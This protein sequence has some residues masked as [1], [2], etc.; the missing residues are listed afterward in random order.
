MA[1][2]THV[3]I[4]CPDCRRGFH[5]PVEVEPQPGTEQRGSVLAKVK[6]AVSAFTSEFTEHVMADPETHPSFVI[7]H[8]DSDAE[9]DHG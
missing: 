4:T 3:P 6:L 2:L 5:C 9:M 8:D 7:Y 1:A